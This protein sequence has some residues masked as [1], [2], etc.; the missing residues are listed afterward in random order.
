MKCLYKNCEYNSG[1]ASDYCDFHRDILEEER[2]KELQK[3]TEQE[4]QLDDMLR[5]ANQ[6]IDKL[7][8]MGKDMIERGVKC[9]EGYEPDGNGDCISKSCID[10]IQK[11]WEAN[12]NARPY[13]GKIKTGEFP[14]MF[15]EGVKDI[16]TDHRLI[17]QGA[18]WSNEAPTKEGYY[19]FYCEEVPEPEL[20][21]VDKSKFGDT[22]PGRV[23]SDGVWNQLE[24][25]H[26][27]LTCPMWKK[28]DH[29]KLTESVN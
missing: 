16:P 10:A 15:A 8:A 14:T 24:V 18:G 12:V 29:R 4:N 19:F 1:I 7:E 28:V 21:L 11:M 23:Y 17:L 26:H 9:P 3:G 5:K 25:F 2:I 27:N 22:H 6:E 13:F 20:V